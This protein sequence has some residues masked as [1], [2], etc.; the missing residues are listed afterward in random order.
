MIKKILLGPLAIIAL[1]LIVELVRQRMDWKKPMEG[2][3]SVDFTFKPEG[4][5]CGPA[6]E[7]GLADLAKAVTSAPTAP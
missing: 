3:S 1:I 6:F 7:K 2:V 5:I 4:D